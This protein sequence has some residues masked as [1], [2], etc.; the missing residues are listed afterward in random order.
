MPTSPRLHLA[1]ISVYCFL[2]VAG[3]APAMALEKD[4][5][6]ATET[7]TAT[8]KPATGHYQLEFVLDLTRTDGSLT[9]Q[10]SVVQSTQL[11]RE[12]RLR[13][14]AD[15]YSEFSGDGDIHRESDLIVWRPPA[16]G[17]HIRY[18]AR[19]D[20]ARDGS[21]FD[22]LVT[23]N[24]ALFRGDDAFPP[25]SIRQRAGARASSKFSAD[26]PADW[27]MVTP[28]DDTGDNQ[29]LI[30]NPERIFDRPVGWIIAGRLGVRRDLIA[31]MEI[32][33][34]GPTGAG[35]QRIGM[36]ALLR[37]TLP[38]M[39]AEVD[40]VPPRLS[41][42]SAGEPMWRGGLSAPRSLYIHAQRPL[43][44]ENATSSLLHEVAHI[45]MPIPSAAQQDWIDEGIAEF[46]SLE[47]LRRSG[48]ISP[49][50][51]LASVSTFA[52][53][54]Q[55][56]QNMSATHASGAVTARAVA[57]FN[58]VNDELQ[59][60]TDGRADIFDLVRLLMQSDE[61]VGLTELRA[62]AGELTGGQPL[63]ALDDRHV[64]GLNAQT[65][66]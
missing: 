15:R 41:I 57:I 14:P 47:I 3:T 4:M 36:L 48:T 22:A 46:T 18:I 26:L 60:L 44:S 37:W 35:I 27:T 1:L 21:G 39:A 10:I 58:E 61:S 50:R 24:W 55:D 29:L 43:L 19:I 38:L 64:P 33:V 59:S 8:D 51:F 25:V 56:V 45:L 30:D 16:R 40:S 31:G 34:A 9:A 11:L 63:T 65:L 13:A 49:E 32:S 20:H 53:R 23:D 54:G 12:V 7:E 42:V 28:F 17:G 6:K 62:M 66:R 2:L 52:R 5:E